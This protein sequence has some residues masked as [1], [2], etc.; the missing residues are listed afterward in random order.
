MVHARRSG[1]RAWCSACLGDFVLNINMAVGVS[2]TVPIGICGILYIFSMFA[3]VIYPQSPYQNSFSR[4][5]WSVAVGGKSL[6][7]LGD[8]R[9]LCEVRDDVK[10]YH[11]E[12]CGDG[13]G[14]SFGTS[15]GRRRKN[16][17]YWSRI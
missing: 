12:L 13:D 11:P 15:A 6:F 1:S 9:R 17:E 4:L 5:I 10:E 7:N 2:T 3:S 14:D 16:V 8:S